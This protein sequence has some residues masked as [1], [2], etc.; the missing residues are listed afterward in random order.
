MQFSSGADTS[1]SVYSINVGKIDNVSMKK[2]TLLGCT[3]VRD[4]IF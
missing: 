1:S 2:L 4:L 3:S